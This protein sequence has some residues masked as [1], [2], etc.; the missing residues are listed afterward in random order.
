MLWS[1]H[2][3]I[4]NEVMQRL[5]FSTVSAEAAMLKEG[6][7]APDKWGDYP[8][9]YGKSNAITKYV[10]DARN[11][12]LQGDLQKAYFCLGVALHYIQDAYT[13]LSS[14]SPN[15]HSWELQIEESYFAHDLQKAL[16]WAFR[17]R[18]TLLKDYKELLSILSR[19]VE[20]KADTLN[21]ATLMG[22]EPPEEWGKPLVDLNMALIASL[23]VARSVL[24][25]KTNSTLETTLSKLCSEYEQHLRNV[26]VFTAGKIVELVGKR[27][28]LK[29]RKKS[30]GILS[31]IRNFL[32]SLLIKIRESQLSTKAQQYKRQ[33]HLVEAEKEYWKA[34]NRISAPHLNWYEFKI[35]RL[36][37]NVVEREL[38][39]ILEASKVLQVDE[40]VVRR[41]VERDI[42]SCYCVRNDQLMRRAELKKALAQN[43]ARDV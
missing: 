36:D 8:H 9:H 40:N 41:F 33:K 27:D 32:L 35:P 16:Q 17:G 24:G 10:L 25:S 5:G 19:N 15:H 2:R 31:K 26:E 23:H 12:F 22:H 38:M 14:R 30:D 20:G 11:L 1:T 21:Y 28:E 39:S 3:R 29:K 43:T 7:L 34:A 4:A 6:V 37:I 18:E 13:S 42:V